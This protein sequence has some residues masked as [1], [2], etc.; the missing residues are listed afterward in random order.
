MGEDRWSIDKREK[1]A[2][3]QW[4]VKEIPFFFLRFVFFFRFLVTTG[5]R[6]GGSGQPARPF[7]GKTSPAVL[8]RR[9][10]RGEDGW[11]GGHGQAF[12]RSRNRDGASCSDRD[13]PTRLHGTANRNGWSGVFLKDHGGALRVG[14]ALDSADG[15]RFVIQNEAE[16]PIV[17]PP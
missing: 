2:Y 3:L 15:L 6:P 8:E 9:G 17:S 5:P 12:R 16:R 13:A 10:H 7:P 1:V 4:P 11:V 14:L